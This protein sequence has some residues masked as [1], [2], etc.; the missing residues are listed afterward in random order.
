MFQIFSSGLKRTL[1]QKDSNRNHNVGCQGKKQAWEWG[2]R[3]FLVMKCSVFIGECSM[4]TYR[5]IDQTHSSVHYTVYNVIVYTVDP[6]NH[7]VLNFMGPVL[8]GIF[9]RC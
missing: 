2:L 9:N 5:W 7:T 4:G 8:C 1:K 6:L 3:E